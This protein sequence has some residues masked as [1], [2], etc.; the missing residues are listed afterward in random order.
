[1]LVKEFPSLE[2]ISDNTISRKLKSDLKYSYQLFSKIPRKALKEEM[3]R[4]MIESSLLLKK[5]EYTAIEW[6]YIDEFLFQP[7]SFQYRGWVKK[8]S[9]PAFASSL[10]Q[11]SFSFIVSL[12][13]KR[14]YGV[15]AAEGTI[16]SE[17]FISY[18][19]NLIDEINKN[20][21]ESRQDFIL[22]ADNAS[23]H[24]SGKVQKFLENNKAS[25]LTICPYSP[26]LNPVEP[27]ISSIKVK[28]KKHWDIKK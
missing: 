20:C 13:S 27:Y 6:I 7:R 16:N 18:L 12:S 9:K 22:I 5:L 4:K 14:F 2:G 24:K 1:M 17:L 11:S 19:K 25:L 23:I 28:I 3:I 15:I 21:N 26:W 10:E 8:N